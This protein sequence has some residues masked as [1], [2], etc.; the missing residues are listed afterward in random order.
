MKVSF[1]LMAR[2]VKI[3]RDIKDR[4]DGSITAAGL[5]WFQLIVL[6]GALALIIPWVVSDR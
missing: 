4:E 5:V 1:S 3:H 6:C 2:Q